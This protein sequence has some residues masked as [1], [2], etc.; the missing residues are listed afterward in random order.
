[1]LF[2]LPLN[3]DFKTILMVYPCSLSLTA[4]LM[5]AALLVYAPARRHAGLES[6]R[7]AGSHPE[8]AD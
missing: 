5:F 4:A 7:R 3:A 6:G 8:T 2:F 1:M